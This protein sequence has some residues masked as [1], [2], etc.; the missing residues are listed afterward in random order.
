MATLPEL[1][2]SYA[3]LQTAT[4]AAVLAAV[5]NIWNTIDPARAQESWVDQRADERLLV[6]VSTGQ[7]SLAQ[8][9]GDYVSAAVRVQNAQPDPDGQPNPFSFAGIASDG[10]GLG[11]LLLSPLIE[12]EEKLA[13]GWEPKK[14][15]ASAGASLNTIVHTQVVDAGRA[16]TATAMVADRKVKYWVRTLTPPSC[17]RCAALAGKTY[18]VQA[19]FFRHPACDCHVV[20]G[21]ENVAGDLR[22]NPHLYF[23]SLSEPDQNKY[24]GA[25]RAQ[26]IRLGADLNTVVN[27]RAAKSGLSAPGLFTKSGRMMPAA[28][29]AAGGGDRDATVKLLRQHGF[30]R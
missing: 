24:F 18:D 4:A 8:H 10:R 9:S 26:A 28:I 25:G 1:V 22:T 12:L 30:L 15:H 16:A 5:N 3:D 7:S 11:T 27:A 13:R 23:E 29:I 19:A 2:Q 17:G 20:P 14:A 6:T 21:V